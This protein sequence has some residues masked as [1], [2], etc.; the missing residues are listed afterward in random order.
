MATSRAT[1]PAIRRAFNSVDLVR[2]G[3]ALCSSHL[4]IHGFSF[5]AYFRAFGAY[6]TGHMLIWASLIAHLGSY[7]LSS[8]VR[9]DAR[10]RRATW[11]SSKGSTWVPKSWPVSW[12]LPAIRT[13]SPPTA[14]ASVRAMAPA[15]STSTRYGL[16]LAPLA[17]SSMIANGCSF[18]GLSEVITT[19][20]ASSHATF[21]IRG[22][23]V[24][25]LS[26]PAPKT[27]STRPWPPPGSALCPVS[28]RAAINVSS[29]AA[30]VWA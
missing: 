7:L 1:P 8:R 20:S 27:M 10:A 22:R 30:G 15:L 11:T 17:T 14:I 4:G 16:P 6:F 13:T 19:L 21:P 18:R 3:L 5:R 2:P 23:L 25:S 29:S 28:S 26:P 24:R 12:P 9:A